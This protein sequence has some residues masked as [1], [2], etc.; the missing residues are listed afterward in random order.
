MVPLLLLAVAAVGAAAQAAAPGPAA[1][2]PTYYIAAD[3]VAWN[4]APSGVNLCYGEAFSGERGAA[5]RWRGKLGLPPPQ[6]CE[7]WATAA[8]HLALDLRRRLHA[9]D[10][11]GC[12]QHLHQ[13]AVPALH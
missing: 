3:E 2:G 11:A 5:A 9:L 10:A 4:Y 13:G 12:G 8:T 1:D 7:R 6:R